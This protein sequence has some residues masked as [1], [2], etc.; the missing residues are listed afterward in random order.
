ML[1]GG[2]EEGWRQGDKDWTGRWS[3]RGR[4]EGRTGGDT[5]TRNTPMLSAR[6]GFAQ[7]HASGC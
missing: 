3:R 2:K 4:K 7:K 6:H 1:E 5:G